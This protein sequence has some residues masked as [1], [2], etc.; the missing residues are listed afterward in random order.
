MFSFLSG[1][2][3]QT[4]TWLCLWCLRKSKRLVLSR[5]MSVYLVFYS[6]TYE[7]SLF[8]F[9]FESFIQLGCFEV[10]IFPQF[11]CQNFHSWDFLAVQWLRLVSLPVQ[12]VRKGSVLGQGTKMP[13][14]L[15]PWN[16]IIKQKQDCNK[17]SKDFKNGPHQKKKKTWENICV[18]I[19]HDQ[20]AFVGLFIV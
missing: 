10:S 20:Q 2:I 3:C 5:V 12:G 9:I 15:K 16:Q 14:A 8:Y 11:F 6:G 17:F 1:P 7:I 18:K 19:R 4:F 13:H